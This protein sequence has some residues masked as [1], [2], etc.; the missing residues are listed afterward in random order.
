MMRAVTLPPRRRIRSL[1]LVVASVASFATAVPARSADAQV[2]PGGWTRIT[3]ME[4]NIEY[5]GDVVDFHS[6]IRAIRA[7]GADVVGI[8]E[9]WGKTAR[10]A[11]R[12]G[13]GY[14]D[15]RLQIVSR[16]PLID[17]PGA[18]G[19]YTFVQTAPGRV[20]AIGN[21]H[22]PAWPASPQRILQGATA[23]EALAFERTYRV[24]AVRPS[25]RTLSTLANSG[26]PSFLLGDFNSP[27]HLD[28]TA[29][30]VGSLPQIKFP[31]HW[32]VTML[33]ER[34]GLRDSYREVHPDPLRTPGLTWPSSRRSPDG[35]PGPHVANDRIDFIF[36]GGAARTLRS[37][38]VGESGARTSG[39]R[40]TRGRPITERSSRR[41]M[42]EAA[43]LRRS[44][45]WR[46]GSFRP[47]TISA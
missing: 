23:K 47:G 45:R 37:T 34:Q 33:A 18:D 31:M 41:S 3:V 7:S 19:L 28:W 10:I 5:G 25:V 40:S 9:A 4:F 1:V 42:C 30:T 43:S 26:I 38:I 15:R 44:S 20:A 39:S 2:A 6:V 22:L 46:A 8:E 16:L 27:S 17:P 35:Y 29:E 36:A 24:P 21:V 11:H 13:W 12:L 14:A 32:P